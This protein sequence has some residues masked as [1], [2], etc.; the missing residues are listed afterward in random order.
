MPLIVN[1]LDKRLASA[2][3]CSPFRAAGVERGRNVIVPDGMGAEDGP[4][5]SEVSARWVAPATG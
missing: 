2:R 1:L 3:L 5:K 4:L